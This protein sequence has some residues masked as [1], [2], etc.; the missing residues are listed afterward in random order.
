[1]TFTVPWN[2]CSQWVSPAIW[3]SFIY[4]KKLV[5]GC[6]C[7]DSNSPKICKDFIISLHLSSAMT[8]AEMMPLHWNFVQ[9]MYIL[10]LTENKNSRA[11]FMHYLKAFIHFLYKQT[12]AYCV[13][14]NCSI[15]KQCSNLVALRVPQLQYICNRRISNLLKR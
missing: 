6:S 8:A 9:N 12:Y 14:C 3:R 11:L 4:R 1:M 5:E 15:K 10:L 2:R 7:T 13:S